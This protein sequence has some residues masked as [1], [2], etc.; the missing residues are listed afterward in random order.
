MPSARVPSI[1]YGL[2]LSDGKHSDGVTMVPWKHGNPLIFDATHHDTLAQ[3]YLAHA[4]RGQGAVTAM[5]EEKT[6]SLEIF[7]LSQ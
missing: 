2:N 3:S 6:A 1:P 4:T 5:D 7:L